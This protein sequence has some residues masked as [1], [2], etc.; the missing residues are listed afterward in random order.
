VTPTAAKAV[1][2]KAQQ[3]GIRRLAVPT[4]YAIGT[5]NTYLIE[6]DPL[7]LIDCG[8]NLASSFDELEQQLRLTGHKIKDLEQIIITHQ[9]I[10][11]FGLAAIIARRSGAQVT[12]LNGLAEYL[13][14]YHKNAEDDDIYAKEL[15]LLYGFPE[16]VVTVLHS[17][18]KSFRNWGESVDVSQRLNDGDEI[19]FRDRTFKVLH[20]PG[21]SPT[22]TLFWDEKHE[23]L[24]AGDHLLK[25]VSSNPLITLPIRSGK[26]TSGFPRR[27]IL[28]TYMGSMKLTKELPASITLTG[29]G[30]PITDHRRLIDHRLSGHEHRAEKIYKLISDQRKPCTA[31]EVATEM[32]GNIAVTQAFLTLSE[33]LGHVDILI[34]RGL[35]SE[36]KDDDGIIRFISQNS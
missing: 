24:F 19:K 17:V 11:H 33:I 22:D 28:V 20:R 2:Q 34:N 6:D 10:D 1:W 8:P 25:K 27:Q 14:D 13:K 36:E 18:S 15:M 32:W 5:V 26:S 23:I 12:A 30:D 35:V 21:H 9:H 7:T 31:Y 3:L 29:H 4:P 16:D